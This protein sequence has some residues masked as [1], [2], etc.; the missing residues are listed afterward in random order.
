MRLIYTVV[1]EYEF[2][3]DDLTQDQVKRLGWMCKESWYLDGKLHKELEPAVIILDSS[4]GVAIERWFA[5]G[6]LHRGDDDGPAFCRY[7]E[8][9]RV[10]IEERWYQGGRLH[11]DYGPAIITRDPVTG[12]E[13]GRSYFRHGIMQPAESTPASQNDPQLG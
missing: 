13:T 6:V 9:T 5:N 10:V 4:G 1:V 3:D 7:H 8:D 2:S 12:R 11:A